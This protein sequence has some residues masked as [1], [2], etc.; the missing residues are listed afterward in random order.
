MLFIINF[1]IALCLSLHVFAEDSLPHHFKSDT[2]PFHSYILPEENI[3][4]ED[5][6]DHA[7]FLIVLRP[8]TGQRYKIR[9]GIGCLRALLDP[10]EE[11]KLNLV[12][13]GEFVTDSKNRDFPYLHIQ[14]RFHKVSCKVLSVENYVKSAF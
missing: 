5:I 14:T 8:E 10:T 1:F 6:A 3:I 2:D 12:G 4:Y 7:E 13:L 9:P 11:I